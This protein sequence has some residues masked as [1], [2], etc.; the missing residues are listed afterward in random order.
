VKKTFAYIFLTSLVFQLG[1][2]VFVLISFQV[3]KEFIVENLC[4]MKDEEE[5]CCQGSCYM[6]KELAKVEA[7]EEEDDKTA[8][9]EQLKISKTEIEY[10]KVKENIKFI[11]LFSTQNLVEHRSFDLHTGN[12]L[13]PYQPPKFI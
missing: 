4:E 3:N 6:E 2:K 12:P 13:L 9:G 8:A 7:I 10:L 5:N 1:L 11:A